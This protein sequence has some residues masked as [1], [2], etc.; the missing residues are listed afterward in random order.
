M[1]IQDDGS[2]I[3]KNRKIAISHQRFDGSPQNLAWWCSL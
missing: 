2:S 3:L 1:K